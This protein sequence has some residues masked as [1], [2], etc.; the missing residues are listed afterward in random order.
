MRASKFRF[1]DSTEQTT[2]SPS[3][4][5]AE[6]ASDSGPEFPMHVVHP[7]PTVWKPSSS[8]YLSRPACAKYSVT[9]F[10]PGAKLDLTQGLRRMP[11]STAFFARRPAPIITWGFD[12]FVQEVI[13]AMTTEPCSSSN[14]S[15]PTATAIGVCCSSIATPAT[16]TCTSGT[17]F[18]CPGSTVVGGSLAGNDSET[19]S[20]CSLP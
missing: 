1:H 15:P 20:S 12:V 16:G 18:P 10:D 14:S 11:S 8:R 4:I 7:Y 19:A 3:T 17:N 13:A 2:R 9:T 5:A 6:I